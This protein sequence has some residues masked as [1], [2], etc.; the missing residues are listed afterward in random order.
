M[1]RKYNNNKRKDKRRNNYP[2]D[3]ARIDPEL[4]SEVRLAL[5]LGIS[6]KVVMRNYGL[7]YR[8]IDY[9][10]KNGKSFEELKKEDDTNVSITKNRR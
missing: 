6:E 1:N 7:T 2:S 4:A 8:Q 10:K 9:C 5:M 3:I